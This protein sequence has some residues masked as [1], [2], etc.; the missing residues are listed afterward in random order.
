[1]PTQEILIM[2]VTRMLSGVCTAGFSREPDPLTGLRWVRPVKEHD[3]LLLGDLTTA[4]GRVIEPGD[5]V[6]LALQKPRPTP[7]HI[8]DWLA[9]F[10]HHRPRLLRRLEGERRGHF[11]AEHVDRAPTDVLLHATRSLC[12]IRPDRVWASFSLD[13]DS[14]KYQARLGFAQ[15]GLTH[16]QA[17]SKRGL[18]VTDLKWE[19]LGRTWLGQAGGTIELSHQDL[20][21]RANAQGVYLALGLSRSYQGECWPLVIGVHLVPDYRIEV[22]YRAL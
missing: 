19:A 14:G 11:L 20:L 18:P 2:A 15:G 9:D 7:P 8:E 4:D 21:E 16:P 3:S 12:L 1:M 5:V 17:N 22:D 13:P 6:E 10:V